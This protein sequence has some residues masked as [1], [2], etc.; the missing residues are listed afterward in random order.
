M[1]GSRDQRPIPLARASVGSACRLL[2]NIIL[3]DWRA[4][5]MLVR[6]L[7]PVIHKATVDGWGSVR[8][9]SANSGGN[10]TSVRCV[11][12]VYWLLSEIHQLFEALVSILRGHRP[13]L[14]RFP[15]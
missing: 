6:W 4:D 8:V 12:L 3:W 2:G 13:R 15:F 1:L 9:Q 10:L 5:V 14:S 7:W 11:D